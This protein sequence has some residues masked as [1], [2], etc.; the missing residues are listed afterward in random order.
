MNKKGMLMA[1]ITVAIVLVLS[2]GG[3]FTYR[4]VAYADSLV[5]ID[6]NPSVQFVVNNQD[7]V[8]NVIALNEDAEIVLSGLDSLIGL[9]SVVATEQYLAEAT[10]LGFIDVDADSEDPN[11]VLVTVICDGDAA[12]TRLTKRL[13]NS[14][15]DYMKNNG[16]WGVCFNSDEMLEIVSEAQSLG[17]ST[18]KLR[19]VKAIINAGITENTE[20]E[21]IE[22]TNRE[23]VALIKGEDVTNYKNGKTTENNSLKSANQNKITA[24]NQNKVQLRASVKNGWN[25]FINEKIDEIGSS[26][27]STFDD[28]FLD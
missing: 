12:Q 15:N 23:L 26:L 10:L 3:Y 13:Q 11:A 24:H 6:I 2:L 25:E 22:M 7:K 4:S 20:Q 16:I 17:I 19:M 27:R 9:D 5:T 18:G 1:I 21:L 28:L 14:V 8:T